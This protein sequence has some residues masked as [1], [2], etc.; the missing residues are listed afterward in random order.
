[1]EARLIR[2]M[3]SKG[4]TLTELIIA[5]AILGI[6]S[7]IAIPSYMNS[8][9]FSKQKEAEITISTLLAAVMSFTD[10]NGR[11]PQ[12]WD[13]L[14]STQPLKIYEGVASGPNYSKVLLPSENYN[15]E[16]E[17]INGNIIKR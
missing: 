1:M 2:Q 14:K 9:Q 12:G 5:V 3:Q 11:V 8:L 6:L 7:A 13:D 16:G 15:I 4:F 10:E 17:I